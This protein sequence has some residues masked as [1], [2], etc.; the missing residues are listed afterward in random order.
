MSKPDP[1]FVVLLDGQ[2]IVRKRAIG[3]EWNE[4]TKTWDAPVVPP[5]AV[6]VPRQRYF[7]IDLGWTRTGPGQ[8]APPDDPPP[9]RLAERLARI[10]AQLKRRYQELDARITALE[11][12]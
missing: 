10:E 3:P 8:W 2:T 11:Q 5:D 9:A 6:A 1:A 12:V 7:Q 4:A